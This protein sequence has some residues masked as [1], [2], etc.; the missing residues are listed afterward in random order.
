MSDATITQ[1]PAGVPLSTDVVPYV[2]L[3][4]NTTKKTTVAN[5]GGGSGTGT[6]TSVSV[7]TANGISGSVATATTTPAITLTLGAI[8]PSAIQVS[9]LTAS[10]IVATDGSKNLQSLTTAT[11]PSL[12]ELSYV[13]G[14][15][16]AIQTQLNAKGVGTVT[17]VSIVTANG[18]SGTVAT[19]TTTPAVTLT[20]SLTSGSIPFVGST[21]NFSQDNSNLFWYSANKQ[22]RVGPTG[23]P[24]NNDARV[25][26][27][28]VNSVND[29]GDIAAQNQSPGDSATTDF[30][31][32]ADNDSTTLIGHYT[33]IGITGSGW[34][35]ATVGNIKTV[36]VNGQGTGY[37]L[38]DVL[39]ITT[40]GDGNGQ[41]T[42]LTIGGTGN[43]T[44]VAL[45][46]NGTGYVN[47][48]GYTTTGGSGTGCTINVLS[49]IDF[50]LWLAN[51]GTIYNSGGNLV[52]STD[53]SGKV[54]KFSTGGIGTINEVARL[55]SSGLSVGLTG[56]T[57]GKVIFAGSTST[58]ITLQG[59]AA[60]L[61]ST[62]TLP[63]LTGTVAVVG[64][65]DTQI[66][67]NDSGALAGDADFTWAK[68][69]NILT[70]AATD[71]TSTINTGGRLDINAGGDGERI[72]ITTHKGTTAASTGGSF[73]VT[74]G[75]GSTTAKGGSFQFTAG[76]GGQLG[77]ENGP[78]GDMTITSGNGSSG[79]SPNNGGNI[80][81]IAG[82][83]NGGGTEGAVKI[84]NA[85]GIYA[86]LDTLSLASSDKTF[87][88]P[89]QSGTFALTGS[90]IALGRGWGAAVAA[91]FTVYY[92]NTGGED[93]TE[94]NRG[95]IMPYSGI[96]KN[97]YVD[98]YQ[99]SIDGS[100]VFTLMKN[101]VA[102]TITVTVTTGST[103]IIGDTTHTV[104]VTAGDR[105]TLRA[106]AAGSSGII[107]L[108][109]SYG[110][111]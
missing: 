81:L 11:Y 90:T 68:T 85:A 110:L 43:V 9:G 51:D 57:L 12:T 38:G 24:S 76:N 89:N 52:I 95:T 3:A 94:T 56:T 54:I 106:A 31:A 36:S 59:Q 15:T 84:R 80:F 70:L 101:G 97:L 21:N 98:P 74:L 58:S 73:I 93:A 66:Q 104:A 41:V 16:S 53:T 49:L 87:T 45:S 79:G 109:F 13:K 100:T 96:L 63:A 20:T 18:F 103:T 92:D 71:I 1:L 99:S 65:S 32:S 91:T 64:G 22:L 77:G 40:G 29:Y 6:V 23:A 48:T 82:G 42:V 55:S 17:S 78:G 105:I 62:L 8:T 27:M 67:F 111:S 26:G 69:T 39:T 108:G 10:Q 33:D 25:R 86:K 72:N 37:T 28:F 75:N 44:S 83:Q 35:P 46:N 2:D 19:A 88:F 4:T 14:V 30:F 7:V 34:N 61:S 102:T 5:L 50:T 107:Y 47:G 60:G